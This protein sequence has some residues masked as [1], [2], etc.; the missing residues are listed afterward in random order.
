MIELG[1]VNVGK[2]SSINPNWV[3]CHGK[4]GVKVGLQELGC[5]QGN[6]FV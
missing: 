1:G 2:I 5:C 4:L 6:S 3:V